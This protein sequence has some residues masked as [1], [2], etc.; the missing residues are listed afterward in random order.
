MDVILYKAIIVCIIFIFKKKKK[1]H[2]VFVENRHFGKFEMA[3]LRTLQLDWSMSSVDQ[4]AP[5][6]SWSR[7]EC[8]G[9]KKGNV[10]FNDALNTF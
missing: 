2:L 9:R 7:Q 5:K 4:H 8:D 6:V 1:K 3:P 10:S